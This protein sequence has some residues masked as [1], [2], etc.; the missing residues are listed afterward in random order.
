MSVSPVRRDRYAGGIAPYLVF[1][2]LLHLLLLYWP[3]HST[4][5]ESLSL[6]STV[7]RF[8]ARAAATSERVTESDDATPSA[9][10]TSRPTPAEHQTPVARARD[11]SRG[12]ADTAR[13]PAEVMHRRNDPVAD[14][15]A[16]STGG[17]RGAEEALPNAVAE[18]IASAAAPIAKRSAPSARIGDEAAANYARILAA[19]LQRHH[20]YPFQLRKQGVHGSGA[21]RLRVQRDGT[22][23]LAEMD[24]PLPDERLDRV[25]LAMVHD[26]NPFPAMPAALPGASFECVIEVRFELAR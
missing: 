25:A 4:D 22:V 13:P 2:L 10:P 24:D 14:V 1:A 20:N 6:P 26:A 3:I 17:P 15:E 19:W 7:L 16:A 18:E 21:L 8:D 12:S 9:S 5:R 23:A 11:A